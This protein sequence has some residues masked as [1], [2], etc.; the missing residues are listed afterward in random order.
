MASTIVPSVRCRIGEGVLVHPE[1]DDVYWLDIPTGE[2]YR[3]DPATGNHDR[4][5]MEPPVGGF[6]FQEDGSILLFG[7]G[8]RII[9]WNDGE[10]S[11]VV[12]G[13]EAEAGMRFNDVIADPRGRVF[14]GSMTDDDHS[15]G[16]LYRLD[17]DETMTQ[18]EEGIE[19]PNGMGFSP[20]AETF[21]LAE[22]NT[23]RIYAY[24]Y[25]VET[26]DLSN[27]RVFSERNERGNYDG[28]TVD[29][30]GGVWVGLWDG[31]SVVRL[32]SDGQ[33]E[34]R[35]EVPAQN[36]TTLSFGGED[37]RTAYVNSASFEAPLSDV[38]AGHLFAL[39]MPVSGSAE[40]YSDVTE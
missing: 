39:E 14:V 7:S 17:T 37:R 3:Y 29:S 8:G 13:I 12:D 5:Q 2:L 26:G 30:E 18:L 33:P 19:L 40:Y 27:R 25:E 34:E 4:F 1:R 15:L 21:Y 28:L 22:T 6:T 36:I 31:G 23:N 38:A 24:D 9:R 20:D 35:L 16:R 10:T 11:V 32:T